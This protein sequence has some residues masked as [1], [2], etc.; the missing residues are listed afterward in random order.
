ME[1][2]DKMKY[3]IMIELDDRLEYIRGEGNWK[4]DDPIQTYDNK[5]EVR[6]AAA[7]WNTSVIVEID[8][9]GNGKVVRFE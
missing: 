5:E 9:L 7:S 8:D 3:A 6:A 4:D 1:Q 2:F